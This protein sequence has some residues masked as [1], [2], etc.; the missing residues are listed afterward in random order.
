MKNL[1]DNR[2]SG[3]DDFEDIFS[4]S[5]K[6]D[7]FENVYSN[8]AENNGFEDFSSFSSEK[9]AENSAPFSPI[10]NNDFS[11][12]Y[13]SPPFRTAA[14]RKSVTAMSARFMKRL[15]PKIK[16]R[17]AKRKSVTR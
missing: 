4:N 13:N 6:N 16:I 10:Q 1:S 7:D 2:F 12:K 9:E 15:F 17:K 8:F 3:N 5:S 11:V 14:V